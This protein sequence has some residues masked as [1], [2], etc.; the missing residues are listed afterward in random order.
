M[1]DKIAE[2]LYRLLSRINAP[3]P[4]TNIPTFW[5][6]IWKFIN[7]AFFLTIIGGIVVGAF[8]IVLQARISDNSALVSRRDTIRTAQITVMTEFADGM[9]HWLASSQD[10]I[11]R[12]IWL[13]KSTPDE[14]RKFPDNRTFDQ[15]RD[16]YEKNAAD[17][18]KLPQPDSLCAKVKAMY[19]NDKIHESIDNLN[20][21]II[22]YQHAG[23]SEEFNDSLRYIENEYQYIIELMGEELHNENN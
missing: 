19:N 6:N 14:K 18:I 20:K 10:V 13:K 7:S 5:G 12:T 8:S 16:I 21:H 1:Q 11:K 17:L 15:T 3:D 23:S 2:E 22:N 9:A 4:E